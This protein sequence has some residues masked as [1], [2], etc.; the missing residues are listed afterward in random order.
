[1]T[2]DRAI[3]LTA[4]NTRI[5]FAVRWLGVLTVQGRFA[6]GRVVMSYPSTSTCPLNGCSK[7]PIRDSSVLLPAPDGPMTDRNPPR[8][9]ARSNCI[10][11]SS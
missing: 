1:M 7:P 8:S 2:E 4:A 10:S 3:R 5:A 11:M 9:T 6:G